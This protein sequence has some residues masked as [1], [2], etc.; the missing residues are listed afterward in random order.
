MTATPLEPDEIDQRDSFDQPGTPD[1]DAG[2]DLGEE[3]AEQ[4]A[5]ASDPLGDDP[6]AR[7]PGYTKPADEA[8]ASLDQDRLEGELAHM[9]ER[10]ASQD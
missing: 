4:P 10:D 3:T 7:L 9:E 5:D 8:Q 1:Q 2:E 6:D